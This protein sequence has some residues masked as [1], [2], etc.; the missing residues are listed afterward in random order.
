V[1]QQS[2]VTLAKLEVA[3]EEAVNYPTASY[4]ASCFIAYPMD[5]SEIS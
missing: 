4:G 3:Q 2:G 5:V 1:I